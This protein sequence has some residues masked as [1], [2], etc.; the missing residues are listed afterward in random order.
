VVSHPRT[1]AN[2][3]RPLTRAVSVVALVGLAAFT[4]P[5]ATV[6]GFTYTITS[7]SGRAGPAAEMLAR[8][9]RAD[10]LN[11]WTGVVVVAMAGRGRM[12]VTAGGQRD[13]FQK[14]DYM[15]FDNTDFIV[16]RPSIAT[17]FIFPSR[18]ST[19]AFAK[20]ALAAPRGMS[21]SMSVDD[22]KVALDTLG[23]DS[24]AGVAGMHYRITNG[25]TMNSTMG[26]AGSVEPPRQM[27]TTAT[28]DFWFG[29]APPLPGNVVLTVT[30]P[31]VSVL[32]ATPTFNELTTRLTA[33]RAGLPADKM[34]LRSATSTVST[35]MGMTNV[36]GDTISVSAVQAVDVDLDRLVLPNGYRAAR[37]P[38]LARIYQPSDTLEARVAKWRAKP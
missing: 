5:R 16:V 21:I 33:A 14:G 9:G 32:P 38:A 36:S 25:F 13:V 23:R 7:H 30:A 24:L 28:Y 15:L 35:G 1:A 20:E 2:F 37:I 34:F 18:T 10:T 19:A 3:A 4:L 26:M 6:P 31:S 29:D 22:V 8:L 11:G 17:Y 12:D 27:T